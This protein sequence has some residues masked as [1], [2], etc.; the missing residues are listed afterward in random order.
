[1]DGCYTQDCDRLD[2]YEAG[3]TKTDLM[4]LACLTDNT[5]LLA[6]LVDAG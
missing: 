2:F 5:C 1:M 4:Q 6:A 3:S